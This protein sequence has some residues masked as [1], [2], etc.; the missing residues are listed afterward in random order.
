MNIDLFDEKTRRMFGDLA[1][2]TQEA[3]RLDG[4]NYRSVI[5]DAVKAMK[6]EN[7]RH[8]NEPGYERVEF[9][10]HKGPTI[11]FTGKLIAE[12]EYVSRGSPE[13]MNVTMEIW[14]TKAGALVA[15]VA[16][17]PVSREGYEKVEAT[18]VEPE[19]DHQAMRFA[20]MDAL[21]WSDG[22]RNMARKLGWSLR[23]EVE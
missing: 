2:A 1:A 16:T 18:V 17:Y 3:R 23:V 5:A 4:V 21:D 7:R 22:A 10:Q 6:R 15:M 13:P 8:Q 20:V 11:E 14:Q 9:K 12:N 19:D